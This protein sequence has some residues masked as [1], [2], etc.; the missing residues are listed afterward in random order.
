MDGPPPPL[1]GEDDHNHDYEK[2]QC[3]YLFAGWG[4]SDTWMGLILLAFSLIVLC[5]CLVLLVK[6]LNSLMKE[7]MAKAIKEF[8][9]ADFPYV[10]WLTGYLAILLGAVV[11]MVIQVRD[12]PTREK[13]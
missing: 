6:L 4:I 1:V 13:K 9:N 12:L 2:Y 11:T 5:S 7:S 10:P 3:G 8:I